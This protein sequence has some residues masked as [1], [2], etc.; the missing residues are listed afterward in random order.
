MSP[1]TVILILFPFF[2]TSCATIRLERGIKID[3]E[4]WTVLGANPQH[5]NQSPFRLSPPLEL[6]WEYNT[7]GGFGRGS[8][9]AVDSFIFVG[10][11]QGKIH[12]VHAKTGNRLGVL[13]VESAVVGAPLIDGITIITGSATGDQ[14]LIS[15]DYRNG[16]MR[17]TKELGGIESSPIRF[18]ASL[19]VTSI[20]GTLYCLEKRNGNELWRFVTGQPIRS[21]PATDG[22]IVVFGCDDGYLYALEN[23]TGKFLWKYKTEGGIYAAPSLSDGLVFFGSMDKTFYAVNLAD[24]TLAWKYLAG[25]QIY[26]SPAFSEDLVF[27]GATDGT[28]SALRITDGSLVWQFRAASIINSSPVVSGEYVY[29][30][31]L[32]KHFYVL[33]AVT[34]DL[35]GKYE[36]TGRIKTSPIIWRGYLIV[37][38]EDDSLLAY[39]SRSTK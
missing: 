35:K 18:G 4:D 32:D 19:F 5:T 7:S 10:T 28:L 15:Y 3:E 8:P 12:V 25:G 30:G 23:E 16:I 1:Q 14:T 13:S 33:E 24:G 17:W 29:V 39:K 21:S 26:A 38:A 11:L 20:N 2:L 9:V 37:A 36:V 34:G 22:R 6:A 27:F 31:S